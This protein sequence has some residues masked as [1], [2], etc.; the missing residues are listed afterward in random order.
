MS[1]LSQPEP[2]TSCTLWGGVAGPG[3]LVVGE[4]ASPAYP[5]DRPPGRQAGFTVALLLRG[6][7]GQVDAAGRP[8]ALRPGSLAFTP[9][10]ATQGAEVDRTR[11]YHD[12]VLVGD[13]GLGRVMEDLGALPP[14]IEH[15]AVAQPRAA[16]DLFRALRRSVRPGVS[17]AEGAA[18]VLTL[19]LGLGRLP[20]EP[21]EERLPAEVL[22]EL[23]ERLAAPD[24]HRR[25]L[26]ELVRGLGHGYNELRLGFREAEGVSLG[27]YRIRARLDRGCRMLVGGASVAATAE[28][29]GYPDPYSF[30]KQF[31]RHL[32]VPPSRYPG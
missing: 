14:R 10:G 8:V 13:A 16:A 11:P 29:L 23:R 2:L 9:A 24:A 28:A 32:G 3:W 4:Q 31:H 25:G 19:L 7:L 15:R 18:A 12:F 21:A 20:E 6:S 17:A 27:R 5:A 1:D 22:A 26:P 30:S